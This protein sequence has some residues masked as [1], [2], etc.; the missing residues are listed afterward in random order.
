[1]IKYLSKKN[2]ND[3]I[4]LKKYEQN[5]RKSTLKTKYSTKKPKKYSFLYYVY[6]LKKIKNDKKSLNI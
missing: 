1:M 4:I 2:A 6:I 5:I 3:I